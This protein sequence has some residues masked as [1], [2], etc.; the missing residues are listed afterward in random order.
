MI[1]ELADYP[2]E[3][4]SHPR[5][6]DLAVTMQDAARTEDKGAQPD[7]EHPDFFVPAEPR[8]AARGGSRASVKW[9]RDDRDAPDYAFMANLPEDATFDLNSETLET[10]FETGRYRPDRQN[11]VIAFALRGAT[12]V[13]GDQ[14]EDAQSVPLMTTR[15]DHRNFRCVLGFYFPQSKRLHAYTGST[16]PCRQAIAGYASGGSAAN[17][18]PT[19]LHTFYIW[20][21][22]NLQPALRMG[23]SSADPESGAKTTVLRS[24]NNGVMETQDIFDLSTPYD[25]VHCSYYLSEQDNVGAAFSSWGCLTVRGSKAPS[26]QWARFQSVLNTLGSKKR[27]DLLLTTGKEAAFAAKGEQTDNL[28]A[29]RAGSRGAEVEKLQSHLGLTPTGYLGAN[30]LDKMTGAERRHSDN[31]GKGKKATG[32]YTLD[33]DASTGWGVF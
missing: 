33:L 11:G 12:L 31:L 19:G 22:R 21:H 25:N 28:V 8:S 30:T 13:G 5:S 10:L 23:L 24:R 7:P 27:V 26:D 2:P 20:R 15:P 16:V 1:E 14:V 6:K 29:L 17:M 32:V 9:P 3:Q 18:L 4:A